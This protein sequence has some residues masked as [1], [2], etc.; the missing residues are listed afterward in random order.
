MDDKQLKQVL[1]TMQE[2]NQLI[3]SHLLSTNE[4]LLTILDDKTPQASTLDIKTIALRD[5]KDDINHL[6][7]S[8][9]EL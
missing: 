4:M 1:E 7:R 6:T 9:E 3:Y 8:I 5:M 2:Q